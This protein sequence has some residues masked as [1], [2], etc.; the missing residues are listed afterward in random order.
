M[1]R[2]EAL[3]APAGTSLPRL[4]PVVEACT[5]VMVPLPGSVQVW[6]A[7][8]PPEVTAAAASAAMTQTPTEF[9]LTELTT[10]RAVFENPRHDYPKRIVYELS[11]EGDLSATIGYLKGGTPRRFDFKREEN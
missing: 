10:K 1:G 11:E 6:S 2:V 8:K 5:R 4:A 3:D 7:S 9:T